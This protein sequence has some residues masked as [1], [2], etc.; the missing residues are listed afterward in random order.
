M[1]TISNGES[2]ASVRAKLNASLA[3]TD[4]ALVSSNNLSEVA[5]AATSFDNIKQ[6]AT[7]SKTGVLR[8]A[9]WD[10]NASEIDIYI[11]FGQSN[12]NGQALVS[13]Y[14]AKYTAAR[15]DIFIYDPS[16]LDVEAYD[17]GINHTLGTDGVLTNAGHDPILA[18]ELDEI[19]RRICFRPSIC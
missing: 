14:D 11:L 2:G 15:S 7:T 1:T 13:N 6:A 10:S 17:V 8:N 9:S 16:G 5:N 3:I 12:S 4:D 19:G 18:Y